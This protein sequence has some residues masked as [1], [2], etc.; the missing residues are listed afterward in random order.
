MFCHVEL[1]LWTLFT[2]IICTHA[3][4]VYTCEGLKLWRI[5]PPKTD[6]LLSVWGGGKVIAQVVPDSFD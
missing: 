3:K 5:I 1:L 2:F 4:A 6:F